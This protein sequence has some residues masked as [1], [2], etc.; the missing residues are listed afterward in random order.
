MEHK[1]EHKLDANDD[2]DDT[3]NDGA[4]FEHMTSYQIKLQYAN[5]DS[6][7]M[8]QTRTVFNYKKK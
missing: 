2:S 3:L 6:N 8:V 4:T 1:M 5:D 7:G